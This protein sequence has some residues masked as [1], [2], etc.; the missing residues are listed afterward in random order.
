LTEISGGTELMVIG[1]RAVEYDHPGLSCPSWAA[2]R[3]LLGGFSVIDSLLASLR[4]HDHSHQKALLLL[5][6]NGN[7]DLKPFYTNIGTSQRADR[8]LRPTEPAEGDDA[9]N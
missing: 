4:V 9:D 3:F 2:S 8:R 5:T 1:A 6:V 7:S